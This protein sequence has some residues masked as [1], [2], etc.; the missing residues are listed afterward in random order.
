[1]TAREK[2]LSVIAI[3]S[4]HCLREASTELAKRLSCW[5]FL[6]SDSSWAVGALLISEWG[7]PDPQPLFPPQP[8]YHS[9]SPSE[10]DIKGPSPAPR[11]RK[12]KQRKERSVLVIRGWTQPGEGVYARAD[13]VE[14]KCAS[15]PKTGN[16]SGWRLQCV[17]VPVYMCTRKDISGGGSFGSVPICSDPHAALY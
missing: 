10:L 15:S 4:R 14:A 8:P 5:P 3:S 13:Q 6:I 12:V 17:C 16:A 2:G 9:L 11:G 1:M 7:W